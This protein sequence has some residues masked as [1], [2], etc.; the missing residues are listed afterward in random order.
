MSKFNKT[1]EYIASVK[2]EAK[3][4]TWPTKRELWESSLV[5]IAFIFILAITTGVCDKVINFV[6]GL[7]L[8]K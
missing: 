1:Q 6:L 4:V 7:F 2:A 5:V 3:K 8:S